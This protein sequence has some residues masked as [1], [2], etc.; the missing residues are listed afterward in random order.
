MKEEPQSE[1]RITRCEDMQALLFNYMTRELGQA[2]SDLVR[3]HLRKCE[4]CQAV[5]KDIQATMNLLRTASRSETV[6]PDHL[7]EDRRTRI[8]R[9]FTHPVIDWMDRHHIIVS[10]VVTI[11]VIVV[12]IVILRR[13]EVWKTREPEGITVTIG[14]PAGQKSGVKDQ[15]PPSR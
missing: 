6:V 15:I 7:S 5:A 10:I 13:M 9:A 3:E 14:R 1:N 4:K 12:L 2:R 8:I 11:A